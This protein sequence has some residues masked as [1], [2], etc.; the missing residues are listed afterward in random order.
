MKLQI[1]QSILLVAICATV[2]LFA[3]EQ[4]TLLVL[5]FTGAE[6]WP[7]VAFACYA[8]LLQ[9]VTYV[10]LLGIPKVIVYQFGLNST[11]YNVGVYGILPWLVWLLLPGWWLSGAWFIIA[12]II[13][14]DAL[15]IFGGMIEEETLR[16]KSHPPV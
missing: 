9:I 1:I 5:W 16:Q 2:T 3:S 15:S 14:F 10:L 7:F 8:K 4:I 11:R 12:N 13:W 6:Y